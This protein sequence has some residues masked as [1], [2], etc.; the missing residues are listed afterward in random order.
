MQH[1]QT[2]L[3]LTQQVKSTSGA[4][5]P[6][7]ATT[8]EQLHIPGLQLLQDF[9]SPAEEA[10]LLAGVDS[11]PWVALAK[12]RVQH[13]GYAFD[14]A[15]RGVEA[16]KR[17]GPLPDFMDCVLARIQAGGVHFIMYSLPGLATWCL[18]QSDLVRHRHVSSNDTRHC[19]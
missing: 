10:A 15:K 2:T 1:L 7:V 18:W 11:Q 8:A 14:Y 5:P 17:L 6:A 12:R 4:L 13:Y 19:K 9:V 3:P 16:N